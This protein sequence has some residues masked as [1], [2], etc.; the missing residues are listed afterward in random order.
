M[1]N[2]LMALTIQFFLAVQ[3]AMASDL[4]PDGFDEALERQLALN[5]KKEVSVPS[6]PRA[7]LPLEPKESGKLVAPPTPE[8][9]RQAFQDAQDEYDAL[10]AKM[11]S[12]QAARAAKRDPDQSQELKIMA[13]ELANDEGLE[14]RGALEELAEQVSTLRNKLKVERSS[15]LALQ[16]PRK[17]KIS[18]A[19]T[20]FNYKDTA[21][22]EV[23]S[24]VDHVTDI[25]LMPG[26]FIT[27]P[28]TA[29]DTVRWN[30]AVMKSGR[31][32]L[33]TTHLVVKPLDEDI[34]TNLIITTDQHVYQIKLKSGDYHTPVVAWN[35]PETYEAALKE[36]T[37]REEQSEVT[38]APE[39]LRFTYQIEGDDYDWKPVRVFDDGKKTFIQMPPAMRVSE[40]PALFLLEDGSEPLLVNYRKKGDYYIVDRL[41]ESAELRVGPKRK[42]TIEL[43]PRKN[44]FQRNFF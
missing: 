12:K 24:A 18:G 3:P 40:A 16:Q 14:G 17:V 27:T 43:G 34:Q 33:E 22:Y 5:A 15:L 37:Q 44:W 19:K 25:Q 7:E 9:L 2:T 28:P 29:G 32:P 23:T 10:V 6:A 38:I 4:L 41:F 11:E 42:I 20:I 35:Y 36:A 21:V 26:E 1:K 30:L 39:E 13:K 8:D 31:A